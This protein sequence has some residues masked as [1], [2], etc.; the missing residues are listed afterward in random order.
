[1]PL[2]IGTAAVLGHIFTV[3]LRF[4]GGKG[5]ATAA[6]VLFGVAPLAAGICLIVWLLVVVMSGYVSLGSVVAAVTFPAVARVVDRDNP[7]VFVVGLGL[8]A[9][10]IY[11]HRANI[12]RLLEGT[13]S[14]FGHRRKKEA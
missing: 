4:R 10:I 2:V 13:E 6:G 11:T 8:S 9:L 14:R 12:R 3:F 5:V 7:Y 1:M